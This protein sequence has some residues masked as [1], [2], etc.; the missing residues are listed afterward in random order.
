MYA[1]TMAHWHYVTVV[2]GDKVGLLAGPFLGPDAH[3]TALAL[4]DT[5]RDL[6][7][8][9]DDRAHWYAFGTSRVTSK[10]RP[11]DGLLNDRLGIRNAT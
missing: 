2:D 7:R 5:A 9:L 8:E 10:T 11:K 6:A 4:V 3:R 1:E